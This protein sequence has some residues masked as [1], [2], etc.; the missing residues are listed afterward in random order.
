MSRH[1]TTRKAILAG[2]WKHLR[3]I[4]SIVPT[5]VLE[6]VNEYCCSVTQVESEKSN[7]VL[8]LAALRKRCRRIQN[9]INC[10]NDRL[11]QIKDLKQGISKIEL[12]RFRFIDISRFNFDSIFTEYPDIW[13]IDKDSKKAIIPSDTANQYEAALFKLRRNMIRC[14]RVLLEVRSDKAPRF[15][16]LGLDSNKLRSYLNSLENSDADN[17]SNQAL[18]NL[19]EIQK[20]LLIC[21][22]KP[23][24]DD[25]DTWYNSLP[26]LYD[27]DPE[28]TQT[29]S[30]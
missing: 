28:K 5:D 26:M 29:N 24:L 3:N 1:E 30:S 11:A 25:T 14:I 19:K 23:Y 7:L 27:I 4:S 13:C 20:K 21:L 16:K 18:M 8:E 17:I 9:Q 15:Q 22:V 2:T 10:V 6:S 12:Y